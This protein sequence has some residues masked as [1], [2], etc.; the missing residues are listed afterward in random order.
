MAS[1]RGGPDETDN[2][3]GVQHQ[4]VRAFQGQPRLILVHPQPS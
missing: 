2:Q 4:S 3:Q 1:L